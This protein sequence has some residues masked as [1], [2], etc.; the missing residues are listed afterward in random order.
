ML[1]RRD[2]VHAAVASL[3]ALACRP[4]TPGADSVISMPAPPAAS[5]RRR[6]EVIGIQLYTVRT[7]MQR[8]V[9]DTLRQLADIGYREVEFAGYFGHSAAQ[10]RA[11]LDRFGLS[12]PSTHVPYQSITE[13]WDRQ[14][15]DALQR[16]HRYLT[17]PWV[18]PQAHTT[19][20]SWRTVAERLTQAGR[21]ARARGL[22]V[23]YH[24]HDF[25]LAPV[26]D[27][28]PL[29]ILLAHTDPDVV[30]F[31]LDIYWTVKAGAD[32][33]EYMRRHPGRFTMFHVKDSSGPPAHAQVTVGAGVIDFAAIL[34]LGANQ[35]PPVAHAF[36]EHDQ[37]ADPIGF[38][39]DSFR[40]LRNLEF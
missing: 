32:P 14:L 13:N 3:G 21:A 16:G 4:R 37:P 19:V 40:H 26:G 18:S 23:A 10:M 34:R 7:E 2:F 28:R 36:V 30:E 8:S 22:R 33:M 6:L 38:A 25:E 39:R 31:Q 9:E 17:I 12:A 5:G 15:D 27:T 24:N 1:N 29:D 20:D 35:A 11:L